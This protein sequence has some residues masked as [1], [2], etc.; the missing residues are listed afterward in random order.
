[1][2]CDAPTWSPRHADRRAPQIL[3]YGIFVQVRHRRAQA[4]LRA[5]PRRTLPLSRAYMSTPMLR[6][7]LA[8]CTRVGGPAARLVPPAPPERNGWALS[9]TL[10]NSHFKT[11]ISVSY[12]QLNAHLRKLQPGAER[13]PAQVR[14]G[15]G[16]GGHDGPARPSR[17]RFGSG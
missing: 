15:G 7:V 14:G 5:L 1:M 4:A 10:R 9:G 11:S 2:R 3:V 6:L 8:E 17:R 13:R 12:L 16:G